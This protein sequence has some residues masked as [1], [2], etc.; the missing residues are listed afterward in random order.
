GVKPDLLLILTVC[1]AYLRGPRRGAAV[2]LLAGLLQ[3]LY[4]GQYLGLNAL[5]KGAVGLAVGALEGKLYREGPH[6]AVPVAACATLLHELVVLL[7]LRYLG[8]PVPFG[9]AL[10]HVVV[11]EGVYNAALTTL[12]YNPYRLLL[13]RNGRRSAVPR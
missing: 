13:Q 5:A 4:T 10:V 1:H 12:V 8:M 2:G 6:L 11:P 3:D 9:F 7:G